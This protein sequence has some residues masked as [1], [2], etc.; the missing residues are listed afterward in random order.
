MLADVRRPEP[1]CAGWR[2]DDA[3]IS[4]AAFQHI[5]SVHF[6]TCDASTPVLIHRLGNF[7]L[8]NELTQYV[9]SLHEAVLSGRTLLLDRP[10]ERWL[11][12]SGNTS[13]SSVFWPSSCDA[14]LRAGRLRAEQ[15]RDRKTASCARASNYYECPRASELPAQFGGRCVMWWFSELT[16]FALRPSL[17]LRAALQRRAREVCA[18]PLCGGAHDVPRASPEEAAEHAAFLALEGAPPWR[19]RFAP[20]MARRLR[21]LPG[22]AASARVIGV[23]VRAGDACAGERV[24]RPPCATRWRG[25]AR[26]AAGDAKPAAVLLATDSADVARDADSAFLAVGVPRALSFGF[27]RGKYA[28]D[29]KRLVE[30]RLRAGALDGRAALH[31]ALLDLALLARAD[32]IV[33]SM[34]SNFPRI[35]LQLGGAPLAYESFDAVWCPFQMCHGGRRDVNRM[36][37]GRRPMHIARLEL[38][39]VD[40]VRTERVAAAPPARRPWLEFLQQLRHAVQPLLGKGEVPTDASARACVDAFRAAL[41]RG[42]LG[43][44]PRVY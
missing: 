22:V 8:G 3:K 10:R 27:D 11:W 14:A 44:L 21:L 20:D 24:E 43:R 38:P 4:L 19:P 36:C 34:Y 2:R 1:T 13:A 7:G 31:E 35:A 23:H 41:E 15:L 32:A 42:P 12:A 26:R 17:P 16:R 9:L 28:A 30:E 5:A 29:P 33:G 40:L 25:L 6:R 18:S 37:T 39:R